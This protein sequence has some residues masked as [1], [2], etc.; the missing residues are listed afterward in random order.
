MGD[1]AQRVVL[2]DQYR[3][4]SSDKERSEAMAAL[5]AHHSAA[6][7]PAQFKDAQGNVRVEDV[8]LAAQCLRALDLPPYEG[9][10]E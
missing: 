5:V 9:Q 1:L 3:T 8:A 2:V 4:A 7:I 10:A 6:L